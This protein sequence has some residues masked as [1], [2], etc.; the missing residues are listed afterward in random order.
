MRHI[1][2]GLGE[3][4]EALVVQ[5]VQHDSQ[6]H[7]DREAEQQAQEVEQ[8]GVREHPPAVIQLEELFKV[9]PADP[10]AAGDAESGFIVPESD[11]RAV[12]REIAENN[13]ECQ[14][15]DQE[16]PQLPVP[17]HGEGE[18]VAQ[19]FAGSDRRDGCHKMPPES[20]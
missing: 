14:R 2:G 8:E 1:D 18:A 17:L 13:E 3:A 19:A 16:H 7:R 9:G 15:G 20:G 4:L 12:H 6:D 11:L 5:L 10:G